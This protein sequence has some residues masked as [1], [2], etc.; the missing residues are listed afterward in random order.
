M[1]V[2]REDLKRLIDEGF[3]MVRVLSLLISMLITPSLCYARSGDWLDKGLKAFP[4]WTPYVCFFIAMAFYFYINN[5]KDHYD[6]VFSFITYL[7]GAVFIGL[8]GGGL[9]CILLVVL[10][11]LLAFSLV[12][13]VIALCFAGYCILMWIPILPFA[14][15][16]AA[17]ETNDARKKSF[18]SI[19]SK[20]V[21]VAIVAFIINSCSHRSTPQKEERSLFITTQPGIKFTYYVNDKT[22]YYSL[23]ENEK[24]V[25]LSYSKATKSYYVKLVSNGRKGWISKYASIKEIGTVYE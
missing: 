11:I 7:L 25:F 10:R 3:I 13:G 6:G 19:A 4:D 17:N 1:L 21:A 2:K 14:L 5:G 23:N 16:D 20:V 9:L 18:Y 12:I 8:L 15:R 24:L 22:Y